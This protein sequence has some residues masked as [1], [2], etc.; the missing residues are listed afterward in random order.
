M[1][2]KNYGKRGIDLVLAL[3]GLILLAPVFLVLLMLLSLANNGKPFFF[4]KRPGKNEKV[5]SII[6]FKTMNDRKD[7]DGNLLSDTERLTPIGMFVRKTSM[8][9][10]PQLINILKGDMSFIGP[11]PLLLHYLPFYTKEESIRHTV[12][13][14]ITGLSQV[15]G[16]NLLPWDQRLATDVYY[17]QNLSPKLDLQIFIKTIQKVVKSEDLVVDPNAIMPSLDEERSDR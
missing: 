7:A 15:S 6:K 16:R 8:D 14:G 5:F 9:E 3:V 2:Y 11:R 17:V 4:Q 10:I 13:P 12:R 1:F